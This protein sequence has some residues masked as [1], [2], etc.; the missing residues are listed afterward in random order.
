MT[1]LKPLIPLMLVGVLPPAMFCQSADNQAAAVPDNTLYRV[2]LHQV[3][4]WQKLAEKEVAQGVSAGPASQHYQNAAGLT[5]G[6]DAMLRSVAADCEAAVSAIESQESQLTA[7]YRPPNGHGPLP[8][9]VR[10]QWAALDA[11]RATV[12]SGHLQ[13]L[14]SAFGPDRF[15][16]LDAYVRSTVHF[17]TTPVVPAK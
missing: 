2:F 4:V 3:T 16:V 10:Q 7:P 6:E 8:G 11:Q 15:Q 17:S 5:N 1:H 14:K 9:A 13:Q 12:I